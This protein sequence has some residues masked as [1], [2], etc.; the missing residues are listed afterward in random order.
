MHLPEIRRELGLLIAPAGHVPMGRDHLPPRLQRRA[1]GRLHQGAGRPPL[2]AAHLLV[3]HQPPQ[4][5]LDLGNCIRFAG[6]N[7]G[8]QPLRRIQRPVRI[9]AHEAL[10]MRP[11]VAPIPQFGD[12]AAFG[13]AQ[14][15]AEHVVPSFPHELEQGGGVPLAN[16]LVRQLGVFRKAANGL[17]AHRAGLRLG[18]DLALHE[19]G[20]AGT[21]EFHRLADALVVGGCHVWPLI[22][23]FGFGG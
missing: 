11:L 1:A 4:L 18:H 12:Q 15:V 23:L 10:L 5:Q 6:G 3:E 14:G 9:V 13:E 17:H 20:E 16:G 2:L 19:G 8:E 7:R 21:Q 22:R